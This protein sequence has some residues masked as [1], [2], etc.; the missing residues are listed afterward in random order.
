MTQTDEEYG[1]FILV[2]KRILKKELSTNATTLTGYR[3]Q[4]IDAY[5]TFVKFVQRYYYTLRRPDQTKLEDKLV[6]VRERF[7]ECLNNLQC[8][9]DLPN[10]LQQLID[11]EQIGQIKSKIQIRIDTSE[12]T[13]SSNSHISVTA[14]PPTPTL[15]EEELETEILKL[16]LERLE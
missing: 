1:K 6:Q 7:V 2:A 16:E 15:T 8:K 5:N 14:N 13:S 12:T 4:I 10:D 9:Y 3:N 11:D